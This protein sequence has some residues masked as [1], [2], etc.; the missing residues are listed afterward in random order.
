M[1]KMYIGSDHTGYELEEKIV[2]YLAS[3]NIEVEVVNNK[4]E[5]VDY[6]DIAK[7]LSKK[8]VENNVL[9]I[10]ICGT[11]IGIS[12]ACNKVKGIR[13]SIC[14]DKYT[15]EM[16]RKHNNL[17]MLCFG[18]RTTVGQNFENIKEMIDIYISQEFEGGRHLERINKLEI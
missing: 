15:V 5:K 14:Y 3:K 1:S 17:N 9:G 10:A 13:A 6:P 7:V 8:V 12:I 11:G 16:A 18:A 2:K 4:E